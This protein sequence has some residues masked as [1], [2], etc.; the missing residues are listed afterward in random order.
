MEA[1]QY[2]FFKGGLTS[3]W[4][5]LKFFS[6]SYDIYENKAARSGAYIKTPE[7]YSNAKCG[8]INIQN[9]DN[10]CFMWCMRYHQTAKNKNDDRTCNLINVKDKYDYSGITYPTSLEDIK[11]F[12]EI[13][14]VCIF[15]YEIIERKDEKTNEVINDIIPCR[16]GNFNYILDDGIYLLRVE[17]G[18][19]S[20][21]IYIKHIERLLHLHHYLK[22]KDNRFCP[23]CNGTVKLCEYDSHISLC[24]KIALDTTSDKTIIQLPKPGSY[25]KF[26][27][28]KNKLIRPY[29]V[30]LDFECTLKQQILH[31]I[32]LCV[33]L[34]PVKIN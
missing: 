18:D 16:R 17:E 32:I 1:R 23:L 25:M 13:N 7:K 19:N 20:H 27:N 30:Y 31:V 24:Y 29:I 5:L 12:E 26:K 9:K 8:L 15:V 3:K 22:D 28:Y 34:I 14:K 11:I 33:T 6:L 10:K 2:V 4:K 21:Y